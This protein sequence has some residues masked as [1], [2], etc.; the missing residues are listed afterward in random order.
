MRDENLNLPQ[1]EY[2]PVVSRPVDLEFMGAEVV[3]SVFDIEGDQVP[4][5]DWL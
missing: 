2:E 3:L 5:V 4:G 1:E